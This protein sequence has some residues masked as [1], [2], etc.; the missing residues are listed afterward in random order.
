MIWRL[1]RL[2]GR[3]RCKDYRGFIVLNVDP[4]SAHGHKL[5][6]I[7][8]VVP[9]ACYSTAAV[10]FRKRKKE[11]TPNRDR[12]DS[13][14]VFEI[15][16]CQSRR[17][18][19]RSERWDLG[20]AV[21]ALSGEAGAGMWGDEPGCHRQEVGVKGAGQERGGWWQEACGTRADSSAGRAVNQGSRPA[22]LP[23]STL[24]LRRAGTFC[25]VSSGVF[26]TPRNLSEG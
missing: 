24:T 6:K 23:G 18:A 13:H 11:I 10:E 26:F 21:V 5:P 25:C 3:R 9:P 2:E 15:E 22:P 14:S 16:R 19:G 4:T 17:Y 7:I 1:K 20:G 8:R 12:E